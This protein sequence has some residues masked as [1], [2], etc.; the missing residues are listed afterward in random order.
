MSRYAPGY[1][2]PTTTAGPVKPT[3][4]RRP[5]PPKGMMYGPNDALIPIK[6]KGP[7]K[8]RTPV[9][10]TKIRDDSGMVP[11]GVV[12]TPRPAPTVDRAGKPLMAKGGMVK[13]GMAKGGM[14]KKG[15]K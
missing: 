12:G 1:T 11:K 5:V 15:K 8:P 10:P 13:K 7:A 2:G 6:P 4:P 14:T 3:G 9:K